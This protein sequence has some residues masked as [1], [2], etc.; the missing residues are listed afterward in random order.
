MI[1]LLHGN[2]LVAQGQYLSKL[3]ASY[4]SLNIT[5]F[6]G[7]EEDFAKILPQIATGQL[8]ADKSLVILKDFDK[9]LDLEQIPSGD[10][11]TVVAVFS[12]QLAATSTVLKQAQK[13]KAEVILLSE[14]EET[15]IFPFLDLLTDKNPQVFNEFAKVY[16]GS[17]SQYIL[18]MIFYQLRKLVMR[19]KNMPEF[20]LKKL[21]RQ[22]NNFP[23]EKIKY[24]YQACLQNDY[25]IKTGL[26]DDQSAL[27]NIINQFLKV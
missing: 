20:A 5:E 18:T 19:P 2:G 15:S 11:L 3:K 25:K 7:K 4:D 23:T 14:K 13:L 16:D 9:D 22:K 17:N 21:Q 10:T 24:L 1:I 12:R 8:F 6:F 26:V 27:F